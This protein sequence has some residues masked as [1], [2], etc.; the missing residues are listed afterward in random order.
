MS[1]GSQVFLAQVLTSPS[2]SIHRKIIILDIDEMNSPRNTN[3]ILLQCRYHIFIIISY[4]IFV[5][6]LS[7]SSE[8]ARRTIHSRSTSQRNYYYYFRGPIR[9]ITTR[10]DNVSNIT[11]YYYYVSISERVCVFFCRKKKNE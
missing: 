7:Y 6:T 1:Y 2:L 9:V 8:I 10:H 4:C 3:N 5:Y 11:P